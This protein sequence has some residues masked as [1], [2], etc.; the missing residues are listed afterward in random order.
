MNL[1][2][3]AGLHNYSIILFYRPSSSHTVKTFIQAIKDIQL[4]PKQ[5]GKISILIG[6]ANIDITSSNNNQLTNDYLQG[7]QH[8]NMKQIINTTTTMYKSRLDHIWISNDITNHYNDVRTTY[9]C[10]HM[11]ILLDIN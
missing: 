4:G 6:E 3:R 10:D 1:Q 5:K 11:P 9:N 7:L 2:L 8:L